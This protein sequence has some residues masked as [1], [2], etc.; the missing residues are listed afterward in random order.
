MEAAMTVDATRRL[1]MTNAS[2]ETRVGNERWL[3]NCINV[4]LS[5][6]PRETL[7]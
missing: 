6:E 2:I 5:H 7:T 4:Y 3:S 1:D